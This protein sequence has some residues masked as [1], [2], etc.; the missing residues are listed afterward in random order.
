MDVTLIVPLFH[1]RWT[2]DSIVTVD[3]SV[4]TVQL[5]S[6][7]D[8]IKLGRYTPRV[9]VSPVLSA[10]RLNEERWDEVDAGSDDSVEPNSPTRDVI[11]RRKK[12]GWP[13]ARRAAS[14]GRGVLA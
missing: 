13:S 9:L 1:Y 2:D 6:D 4:T 11:E 10:R 14:G 12:M 5:S 7:D 8:P 3:P